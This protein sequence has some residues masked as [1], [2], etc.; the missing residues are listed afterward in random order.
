MR[1]QSVDTGGSL[2]TLS[3]QALRDLHQLWFHYRDRAATT[4]SMPSS[5][6]QH[7]QVRP[8]SERSLPRV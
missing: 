7:S 1:S 4:S 6:L 8:P 5:S 2:A 3:E